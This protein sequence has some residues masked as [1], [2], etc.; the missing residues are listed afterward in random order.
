MKITPSFWRKVAIGFCILLLLVVGPWVYSFGHLFAYATSD[1]FANFGTYINGIL[2][3]LCTLA[4]A[5]VIGYQIV[6]NSEN[7]KLE[8]VVNDLNESLR[9]LEIEFKLPHY[10]DLP[11]HQ[12]DILNKWK[13]KKGLNVSPTFRRYTSQNSS[14]TDILKAIRLVDSIRASLKII[15]EIDETQHASSLGLVYGCG[16][17]DKIN[18]C[19]V[20]RFFISCPNGNPEKFNWIDGPPRA[21]TQ[22]HRTWQLERIEKEGPILDEE[23]EL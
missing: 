15:K 22:A 9:V 19:Q 6:R 4:S 7:Q 14:L 13:E 8:R 21:V 18:N 20:I 10:D 5:A 17:V 1:D 23:K 3:P 16:D 11:I 12:A 2:M